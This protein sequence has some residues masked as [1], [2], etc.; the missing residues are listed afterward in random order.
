MGSLPQ[1]GSS[2]TKEEIMNAK[3]WK[4]QLF[5]AIVACTGLVS[6]SHASS[7]G[8]NFEGGGNG[9]SAVG[10]A[11]GDIAGVVPQANYNNETGSTGTGLALNDNT[12]A[13]TGAKLTFSGGSGV[14]NVYANN[15]VTPVGGNQELNSGFVYG[16]NTV[17]V[18]N[19]PYGFYNV[20]VYELND[21]AGREETTTLGSTSYYGTAANPTDSNHVSGTANTYLYTQSTSTDSA[22]PTPNGDY[23]LF[24]GVSGSTLMFTDSAPGN[25]YITGFEIVAVPEPSSVIALV[26]LCGMGLVGLVIRRRR[27]AV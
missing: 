6:V 13:L 3:N 2:L 23:V 9:S 16:T 12:G 21:A 26:G 18:S 25:G 4:L 20:Y 15:S 27:R 10:L 8:V 14:Y 24:T 22:N 7:I 11:P 1:N 17:T 19:V 5:A